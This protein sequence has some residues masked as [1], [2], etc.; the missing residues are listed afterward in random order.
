[1]I[2]T[3]EAVAGP[4]QPDA[5]GHTG[6]MLSVSTQMA[7]FT[8]TM[9]SE[10]FGRRM[11]MCCNATAAAIWPTQMASGCALIAGAAFMMATSASMPPAC[12]GSAIVFSP[13]MDASLSCSRAHAVTVTTSGGLHEHHELT[14]KN[15]SAARPSQTTSF[16][17]RAAAADLTS[18]LSPACVSPHFESPQGQCRTIVI[19]C[20]Q[21]MLDQE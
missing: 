9:G 2:M 14:P 21:Q 6:E 5:A 15:S 12:R 16:S 8:F 19:K 11:R 10:A 18:S 17:R 4:H 20:T 7:R 1:M 3:A 13:C